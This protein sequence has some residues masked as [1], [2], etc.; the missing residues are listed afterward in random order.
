MRTR[1][2]TVVL[3]LV[4]A[5]ASTSGDAQKPSSPLKVFCFTKPNESGFVDKSSQGRA[6][7]LKDLK[8]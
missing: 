4:L 7:S 5:L 1:V 3:F 2:S 6:D 8:E